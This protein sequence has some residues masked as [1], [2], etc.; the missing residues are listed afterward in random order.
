MKRGISNVLVEVSAR[1]GHLT[2]NDIEKLFG[3][4]HKL[5]FFRKLSQHSDFAAAEMVDIENARRKIKN[6]RIVGPARNKRNIEISMT[7]AK[8]L[9]IN[10]LPGIKIHAG[11]NDKKIIL[12]GPKG[13]VKVPVIIKQRHIHISDK[14]AGS[15]GLKAKDV[16]K[17]RV[18]GKRAVIFEN[19]IV[20][21][22]PLYNLSMHVDTDEGNAAGINIKTIGEIIK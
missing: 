21:V 9:K 10:P 3:K 4:R 5:K 13:R 17:V 15:L 12:T 7:D 16:I 1:H 18:G 11:K 2:Q 6:V 22:D 20:R 19:V 8:F 14:E